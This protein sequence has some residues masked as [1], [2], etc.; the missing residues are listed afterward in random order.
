MSRMTRFAAVTLACA[1]L[2]N[3]LAEVL[4]SLRDAYNTDFSSSFY[5][6]A[7]MLR[8]GNDAIYCSSCLQS[9]AE[10]LFHTGPAVFS[11]QYDNPPLGAWLLQPLTYLTPQAALACFLLASLIAVG[12]AA[13]LLRSHITHDPRRLLIAVLAFASLP[14]AMTFAYGQWDGFLVL[15]AAGAYV[16]LGR[17][18]Q[19]LAGLLIAVLLF[20]PQLVWLVP[21][22]VAIAGSWRILLGIVAGG[23]VWAGSSVAILGWSD[24]LLWLRQI[25]PN[26]VARTGSSL[27]HMLVSFGAAS[28]VVVAASATLAMSTTVGLLIARSRLRSLTGQQ[29]LSLG[30]LVS[31]LAAPHLLSYDLIVLAPLIILWAVDHERHALI[32]TLALSAA[33]LIDLTL[34]L[35][36]AIVEAPAL[37]AVGAYYCHDLLTSRWAR[38]AP[39]E[40]A[41][42]AVVVRELPTSA[43]AR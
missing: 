10:Q 27:P 25:S 15:A 26:I 9:H 34:P 19:F 36:W 16:A 18:R 41:P 43:G 28:A 8:R 5:A 12:A 24:T 2:G 22:V 42:Y 21:I 7:D 31:M 37:L 29:R 32:A 39:A 14:A 38:Q 30:L 40:L 3:V 11:F 4:R 13:W 1:C 20:K 17:D 23:A 33:F 35:S 6:A